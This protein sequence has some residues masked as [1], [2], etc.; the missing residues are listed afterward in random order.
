MKEELPYLFASLCT[1]TAPD[2][3]SEKPVL[4][5]G[6]E[7]SGTISNLI[8]KESDKD[9]NSRFSSKGVV[10]TRYSDNLIFSTKGK[11]D[12]SDITYVKDLIENSEY[13]GEKKPFKLNEDKFAIKLPSQRQRILG[14]IINEKANVPV[15]KEKWIRSRL[16]HFHKD[17]CD[18]REKLPTLDI[19]KIKSEYKRLCKDMRLVQGKLSYMKAINENKFNKYNTWLYSSSMILKEIKEELENALS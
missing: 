2:G 4:A 7:T 10:Y 13:Y 14:V 16:T 15:E 9:I 1:V 6:L 8:L 12:E 17:C 5:M 18:F 19:R 3:S 11:F